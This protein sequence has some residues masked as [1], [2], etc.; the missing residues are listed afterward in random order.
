MM[1]KYVKSLLVLIVILSMSL[2]TYG[3]DE[4]SEV[5]IGVKRSKGSQKKLYNSVVSF[6]LYDKGKK[7]FLEL[8][9]SSIVRSGQQFMINVKNSVSSYLYILNIDSTNTLYSLFPHMSH[10][11]NPLKKGVPL[12]L[13]VADGKDEVALYEFDTNRGIEN[14]YIFVSRTPLKKIEK[15]LKRIPQKGLKL[16]SSS[17]KET[18]EKLYKKGR[19]NIKSKPGASNIVWFKK[20]YAK[21]LVFFHK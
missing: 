14:Y 8:T 21:K 19:R 10:T 20:F 13:P 17:V 7:Q 15:I 18:L 12:T 9:D 11:K 2:L 4:D 16:K 1:N 3:F 5:S 6:L